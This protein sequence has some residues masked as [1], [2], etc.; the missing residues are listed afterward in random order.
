ML[1]SLIAAALP[2]AS[3]PLIAPHVA[4]ASGE[5]MTSPRYVSAA[6]MPNGQVGL[7]F[8]NNGSE[9]RFKR[10]TSETALDA[11]SQLSTSAPAYP[12]LTTFKGELVAAYVGTA[13]KLAFRISTDNGL[14]GP[15]SPSH[16]GRRASPVTPALP[17]SW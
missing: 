15:R 6:V 4:A 1:F 17:R 12:Q 16:S 14:P 3:A 5:T 11:S 10:Y 9:I 7:L 8:Q 13:S 2:P